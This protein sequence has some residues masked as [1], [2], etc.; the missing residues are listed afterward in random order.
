MV[1]KPKILLK[2]MGSSNFLFLNAPPFRAGSPVENMKEDI[3][4][5]LV[6]GKRVKIRTK[7]GLSLSGL[8]LQRYEIFDPNYI[9]LKLDNGYNIGV[10]VDNILEAEEEIVEERKAS[11]EFVPET[12]P[13]EVVSKKK[14]HIIATGGTIASKIDY[15]TGGVTPVL[16]TEELLEMVPELRKIGE[17]SSEVLMSIFSEN[18]A[19]PQWEEIAKRV[20]Q[21]QQKEPGT[22]ILLTH[23]TDTLAYTAAALSFALGKLSSPVAVLGSQRSSDRPSS[24]SAFN[25]IAASIY[26]SSDIC[27]VAAVMHG[28]TGDSYAL[29]HRGTRVRKMHSSRRDAFQSISSLPIA[30]IDPFTGNI[31]VLRSD[32]RKCGNELLDKEIGKPNYKFS[33]KVSLLK[34]YPGMPPELIDFL[35]ERGIKGIIL[36]G[37]GLGHVSE[38]LIDSI[39]RA[40]DSGIIVGMTTQCIFGSVNLNVYSTGRLL[41]KAGVIGLGNMLP[42]T[43]YVKLS[44]A[45]GNFGY[46]EAKRILLENIAGEYEEREL[47]SY[48]PMWKHE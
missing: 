45:L 21:Y 29:A 11:G 40:T 3:S 2:E 27:E 32:A 13:S 6:P 37:T 33:D 5:L 46:E 34:F 42:E 14:I 19:P 41:I 26:A 20:Y 38:Q 44:W 35:V 47:P 25:L 17:I 39:K 15:V 16:K 8:V 22:G 28:E 43:A 18:M 31:K 23:G 36:E 12:L 4:S 24:D 9:T 10:K 48:F 7:N 1:E 30:K